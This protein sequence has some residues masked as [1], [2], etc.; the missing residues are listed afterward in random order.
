MDE[1]EMDEYEMGEYK[2]RPYEHHNSRAVAQ[3]GARRGDIS[4]LTCSD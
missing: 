2:I 1:Y 4:W 3:I